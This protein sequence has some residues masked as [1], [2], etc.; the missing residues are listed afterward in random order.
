MFL[1]WAF[2]FLNKINTF[3]D[4]IDKIYRHIEKNNKKKM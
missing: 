2:L 4:Y 3:K 1:H